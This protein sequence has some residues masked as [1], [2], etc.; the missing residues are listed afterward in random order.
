[1]PAWNYAKH[2]LNKGLNR[3]SLCLKKFFLV[4]QYLPLVNTV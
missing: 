4:H 2:W 1:L 3:R